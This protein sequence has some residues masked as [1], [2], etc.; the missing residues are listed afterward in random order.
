MT[1]QTE[2]I[3][4]ISANP[5]ST[6]HLRV[7]RYGNP[8][9]GPKAYLHSSLHADEWPGL[10]VLHHLTGMLDAADAEGRISGEIVLLPYA[11]PLGL[12]Q[13]INKKLI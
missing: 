11:N 5:G 2:I 4:L 9:S 12:G 10:L 1:R 8:G 7:H 13:R 3:N 6:R